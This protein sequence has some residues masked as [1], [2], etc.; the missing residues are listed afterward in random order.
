MQKIL[1]TRFPVC[2][3]EIVQGRKMSIHVTLVNPPY[4]SGAHQHPPF[5]PLGLGYLAAVLE[6]NQYKVDVIDGQAQKLSYEEIKS[7]IGKR[8]PNIVGTTSTTLTYKSGLEIARIA[9][10][11]CP[12]CI[13]LMGG[14]HVT[15][16]DENALKECPELDVV[17]RK[18][19]ENTLL[20]LVQ[21]IEA[22]KSF[23]NV[24][25]TTCRKDGKIVRN[26]DRPYIEDLDSLPF[27]AHNLWPLESLRKYG[28]I[29]YPVMA[30]RGCVFW[31]DF[32]SAV[33]MFGRR[34]RMRSPK[35]AVDEI[36]FLHKTYGANQFT[37]YDD[38][39]TVDQGRASEICLEIRKRK[40]KIKWDCETRVD[41]VTKELLRNMRDAGCIAIWFGVESGSQRV[42]DAMGKGFSL[43]QTMNAFNWAKEA[44]LM[45]VAGAILGFPGETRESAWETIK[46]LEKINP[47]DVGYYIA[48]P[49]PGT[50]LYD[51]VKEKGYLKITD[52]NK[53]DT[54]TPTFETPTLSMQE[55]RD[56]REKAFHRFYIRPS[57]IL[58]MFSKGGMYGFSSSRTALAHLIRAVKSKF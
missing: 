36:E 46:L 8:Q 9:K 53:Y 18:E 30:S 5:T 27:P 58:H 34:F 29:V 26:P 3:A 56:I 40:L 55:L 25:G 12:K 15:F 21:R 44:G 38:A 42:I 32:C 4:P 41:M 45:A 14:S 28:T 50:P 20:E 10:A 31:C 7:E 17:V 19:G 1:S 13:T 2:V 33:R 43:T 35:N 37:F 49:Y 16:W 6:K 22:G 11:V 52:F 54:A 57:Y 48:T 23:H 51:V 24:I 47:D 39:F